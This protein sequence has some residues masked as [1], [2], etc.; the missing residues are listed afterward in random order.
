MSEEPLKTFL[1]NVSED[2]MSPENEMYVTKRDGTLE[3]VDFGK[4]SKRIR[5]LS[6]GLKVNADMVSQ[7][8]MD[9]ICANITTSRLDELGAQ[10]CANL[11]TKHYDYQTLAGRIIISNHQKNTSPSFSETINTLYN[12]KNALGEH[13]PIINDEVHNIIQKHKNKLNSVIKYERDYLLE[14]FGFM[15]LFRSYLMKIDGKVIERPQDMYLRVAVAIH[16]NDFKDAI[17][18]YDLMSEGYFTH[19]T[20]TLYNM[21]TPLEQGSSCFLL[22]MESDSIE[23]IYNTL[24]DCAL[25]SK[26]A[27]GIGLNIHNIR[28]E[29]SPIYGT[30]G[31]SNGI[32]PML[33]VFN[34][35]AEYVDQGGGK[36]KGSFAIYLEPWH[37]DIFGFLDL[38]KPQGSEDLRARDLFYALW[39]PNLFMER[40]Q[41]N[42]QWTLM[43]PDRCPGLSDVWGP[44]FEEL[45]LKYESEG[46]GKET[47]PAQKLWTRIIESQEETGGPYILFKDHANAKSNQQNLGTIKSSNLCTEIIEYTSKDE[48]AVCN[49]ASI[50]LPKFVDKK[51]R[52]FDFDKLEEVTRVI[53]KNLNK[54]I[55]LNYYPIEKCRR[56][57]KRH[58]PIGIG[59]QG[60]ADVY[61]LMKYPFDSKEASELNIK[62]FERIY[63]AALMAS[64]EIAKK[65]EKLMI[66]FKELSKRLKKDM[67]PLEKK[68][69][70]ELE[71][72][73]KPIPEELARE[74]FLGAYCTFEGSPAHQGKLQY[75][76]W[77][78][79]PT[80]EMKD[81]FNKL[82]TDIATYGMRNSLLLAPMPTASTSQILGNNEACEPYTSLLYKRR[83]LAGEFIV[84]NKHLVSDLIDLELWSDALKEEIIAAD[85]SIQ[86]IDSIPKNIKD[87]YKTAWDMSPKVIIDQAADRGR[88]IC[89]S[90]SMNLWV[91]DLD[92]SKITSMYFYGWK[93]GL[94]TGQYYMRTQRQVNA[95]KITIN[96]NLTNKSVRGLARRAH[97]SDVTEESSSVP[98]CKIDDPECK[99]C[100]S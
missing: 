50:G 8:I 27:G 34:S 16:R 49:L 63:Y 99:S 2:E 89:Q 1:D 72:I 73:L 38:K 48:I 36:R 45:Y 5:V 79:E 11:T 80:P 15:T 4:V 13:C 14:Y 83:T 26:T 53:V 60:L 87:L 25:I 23:G 31:V 82:K 70:K 37:A 54:I 67:T 64:V 46:R 35:T 69:H 96:P 84:I 68:E 81:K 42:G 77:N 44:K 28:S 66:R 41:Q 52:L 56:S 78:E 57:N 24:K 95:K 65:R 9:Q 40:V 22:A 85:G 6:K 91:T 43:S 90:Q 61:A 21:G 29:G 55:D 33:K 47:I 71:D 32:I 97:K 98:Q 76:L 7:K 75:D 86:N 19:A 94:K 17:K 74:T 39:I 58:R 18:T 20:P 93:R 10:I 3:R 51:T 92:H 30:N 12:N 100:G 62:I 59:V 88:Y